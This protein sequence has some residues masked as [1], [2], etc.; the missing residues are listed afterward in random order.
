MV[1]IGFMGAGKSSVGRLL[2]G[3]TGLPLYETDELVSQRFGLPITDIFAR[4]GESAFRDAESDAVHS[5]PQERA[6]IVSGGGVVLREKNVER[7][8]ALGMIVHLS[9]SEDTL[10][11]RL[12]RDN[13][14]PLLQTPDPRQTFSELLHARA[15]FYQDAA[16][17]VIDT[18]ALTLEQVAEA[19]LQ[20]IATVSAAAA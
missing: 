19:V 18:S 7:L 17:F 4:Y 1:L 13:P 12:S 3:R 2:A 8:R 5:L 9:A 14:R 20:K 15:L 11:G 16:D 6:I 10:L